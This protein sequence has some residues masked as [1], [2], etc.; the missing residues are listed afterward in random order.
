MTTAAMGSVTTLA[1]WLLL[2][3]LAGVL[4]GWAL[5]GVSAWSLH[6]LARVG[7]PQL[8]ALCLVRGGPVP[9]RAGVAPGRHDSPTL[10]LLVLCYGVFGFGYIL[11]ATFL[12]ALA[13]QMTDEP[14]VFGLVWPLFGAAAAAST[15][16]AGPL[17]LNAGLAGLLNAGLRVA[18]LGLMLSAAALWHLSRQSRTSP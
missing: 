10:R 3:T 18:A 12:P 13:R 17:A 16:V 5:V 9:H 6:E 4:S 15:Q 2:R 1:A 11:P 7:R 14:R 8:A